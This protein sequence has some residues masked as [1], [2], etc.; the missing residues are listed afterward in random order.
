MRRVEAR[1]AHG[2]DLL[3]QTHLHA[4]ERHFLRMRL[5]AFKVGEAWNGSDEIHHRRELFGLCGNRAVD[6]FPC[7]QDRA[8]DSTCLCG[9][10]D[11]WSQFGKV[12]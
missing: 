8:A 11:V 5:F 3:F 9:L 7:K 4:L 10:V 6:P 2:D 1:H 12:R